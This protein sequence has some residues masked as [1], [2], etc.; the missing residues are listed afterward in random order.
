MDCA[1]E[2]T[3]TNSQL[4]KPVMSLWSVTALG[5][6]AMVGAGVFAV[7]G[8]AALAAGNLTYAAFILGGLI[9]ALSG[10][11]YAILAVHFPEAGGVSA[12]FDR[13]FGAARLS[14]T[15][16]LI[17]M[18]TIAV[19]VALVAKAFG[20][21]AAPLLFGVPTPF[22]VNLFA[23]GIVIVMTLLNVLS[24]GL[25]GRAEIALVAIK[26][27]I[28]GGLM[29]A[30]SASL[31]GKPPITELHPGVMGLAGCVGLTFLAYAGYDNTANAASSVRNPRSTIPLAMFMAIGTVVVLYVGL[32]LI[33]VMSLPSTEIAQHSETVVAEAARP[34]LGSAGY[35]IVSIGALL[36]TAAVP[37]HRLAPWHGRNPR[38]YRRHPDSSEFSQ[39]RYPG[40]SGQRGLSDHLSGGLRCPLAS[41]RSNTREQGARHYRF[42]GHG[43]CSCWFSVDHG[44]DPTLVGWH[45]R[46]VPDRQRTDRKPCHARNRRFTIAR[47][48]T[49]IG[50]AT[51]RQGGQYR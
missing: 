41:D 23:S 47:C 15:L 49:T 26:I 17:Y 48:A 34:V 12:Y 33:V 29:I 28:L 11:S 30:G 44:T 37:P 21:Y 40:Q 24:S 20:G 5:I 2:T 25:V 1:S 43:H 9:A 19:T 6:G 14:G 35:I 18:L 4:P 27:I 39:P 36:A 16:S 50:G 38:Q 22:L 3:V 13:A 42:P 10:Y 32:S 45:D 8:Q 51:W 31:I 7:M 46:L